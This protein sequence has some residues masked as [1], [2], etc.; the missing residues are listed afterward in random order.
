[1]LGPSNGVAV[2]FHLYIQRGDFATGD[3]LKGICSAIHVFP[4]R[5]CLKQ[6]LIKIKYSLEVLGIGSNLY[7]VFVRFFINC[8]RYI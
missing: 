2:F 1:M 7:L 4:V 3:K 6:G 5:L 8:L